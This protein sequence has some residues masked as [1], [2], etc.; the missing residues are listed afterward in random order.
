MLHTPPDLLMSQERQLVTMEESLREQGLEITRETASADERAYAE[1]DDSDAT[2]PGP[3]S[4]FETVVVVRLAEPKVNRKG[5]RLAQ[6]VRDLLVVRPPEAAPV[7][8]QRG[9]AE[10]GAR[11]DGEDQAKWI[12]SILAATQAEGA[13]R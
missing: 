11:L 10:A 3:W 12:A 7:F 1:A 5:K 13:E 8:S 2:L 9:S 4:S 6:G